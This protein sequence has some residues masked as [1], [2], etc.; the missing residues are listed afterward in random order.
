M[1]AAS[2]VASQQSA[3]GRD[4]VSGTISAGA[5]TFDSSVTNSAD[6]GHNL[7]SPDA[8]WSTV[9]WHKSRV[10]KNVCHIALFCSEEATSL[11]GGVGLFH[12][13]GFLG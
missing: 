8:Y 1:T 6:F 9:S 4:G 10:L 5:M 11:S 13:R 12:D 7:D 3:S 2:W